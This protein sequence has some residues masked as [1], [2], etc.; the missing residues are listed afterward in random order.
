VTPSVSGPG[1]TNPSVVRRRCLRGKYP[2]TFDG[3]ETQH[4]LTFSSMSRNTCRVAKDYHSGYSK[5]CGFIHGETECR[6]RDGVP[7]RQG[8]VS[9]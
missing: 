8:V 9:V 3:L 2:T 1:D 6:R 7:S 4:L 5:V